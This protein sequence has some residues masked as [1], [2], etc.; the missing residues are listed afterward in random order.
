MDRVDFLRLKLE[1]VE[2]LYKN[3]RR[4]VYAYLMG[5][6]LLFTFY[7]VL[8]YDRSVRTFDVACISLMCCSIVYT[9]FDGIARSFGYK[10]DIEVM[11]LELNYEE[12]I[13]K[14]ED[15]I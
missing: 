1:N 4:G 12:E 13:A 15:E 8:F 9:F 10:R 7:M 14:R 11:K 3:Y 2:K 5:M 6:A